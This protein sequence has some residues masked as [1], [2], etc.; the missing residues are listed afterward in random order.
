MSEVRKQYLSIVI[1]ESTEDLPNKGECQYTIEID[2]NGDEIELIPE[3]VYTNSI[4]YTN[5]NFY[6]IKIS[7]SQF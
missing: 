6:K 3:V 5:Q 1:C 4:T 2:N 7:I